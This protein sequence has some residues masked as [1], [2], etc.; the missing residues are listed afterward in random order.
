VIGTKMGMA[1][2][3]PLRTPLPSALDRAV[4]GP[5]VEP[6]AAGLA[7][8]S[9]KPRVAMRLTLTTLH[10]YLFFTHFSYR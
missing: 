5:V 7:P 2:E 1:I 4:G 3:F 10:K 9:R 8:T 6:A